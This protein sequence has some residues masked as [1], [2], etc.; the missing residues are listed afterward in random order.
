MVR[1]RKKRG[2]YDV[3][4]RRGY[5]YANEAAVSNLRSDSDTY[6]EVQ[7]KITDQSRGCRIL[8]AK[9]NAGRQLVGSLR[10]VV[11]KGTVKGKKYINF[12]GRMLIS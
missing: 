2:E 11:L 7:M 9:S 3:I 1:M 8:R 10:V 5:A 12:Q 6:G 4:C